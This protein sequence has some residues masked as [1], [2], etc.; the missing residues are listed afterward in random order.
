MFTITEDEFKQSRLYRN[1]RERVLQEGRCE[2]LQQG[3]RECKLKTIPE[4]LKLGLSIE[5]KRYIYL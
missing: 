5:I 4:L 3:E 2:S 1:I